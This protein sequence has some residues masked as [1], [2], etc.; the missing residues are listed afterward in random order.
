[1]TR[2]HSVKG[3]WGEAAPPSPRPDVVRAVPLGLGKGGAAAPPPAPS[4]SLVP[5]PPQFF[6]GV[7]PPPVSPT[8]P[9][10]TP[11]ARPRP[12]LRPP[13]VS[14]S[15]PR[16]RFL[17]LPLS[18]FLPPQKGTGGSPAKMSGFGVPHPN[19]LADRLNIGGGGGGNQGDAGHPC[20]PAGAGRDG[21]RRRG[22][23]GTRA[24]AAP[25][26]LLQRLPGS[27]PPRPTRGPPEYRLYP[28]AVRGGFVAGSR[29]PPRAG[30]GP[31]AIHGT[32]RLASLLAACIPARSLRLARGSCRSPASLR[33]DRRELFGEGR[34]V[35]LIF[36]SLTFASTFTKMLWTADEVSV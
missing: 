31:R 1:M 36:S 15:P 6:I 2:Y 26:P 22:D 10:R 20:P 35:C 12:R 17:G 24:A 14:P 8:S 18:L 23:G 19:I 13:Q 29:L 25:L 27:S 21:R 33:A 5:S 4:P 34:G 32:V 16:P 28:R 3:C 30:C 7:P 11:P 9:R